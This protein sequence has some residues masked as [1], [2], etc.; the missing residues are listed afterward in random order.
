MPGTLN[1]QQRRHGAH[2]GN[3]SR[4][5]RSLGRIEV[6]ASEDQP[7]QFA[8]I[9]VRYGVEDDYGTLFRPG[10]FT[11]RLG[12]KLPKVCA[13][14]DWANVLGRVTSFK[15]SPADLRF[16]CQLSGWDPQRQEW[17]IPESERAYLQLLDGTIDEFSIGFERYSDSTEEGVGVWI[18]KAGIYEVSLV[19]AG[20]V[21]GTKLLAVRSKP[22]GGSPILHLDERARQTVPVD[23]VANVLT[24]LSLGELDLH[25]ALGELKEHATDEDEGAGN[26]PD[27]SA[28]EGLSDDDLAKVRELAE[29][30]LTPEEVAALVGDDDGTDD[31]DPDDEGGDEGQDEGQDDDPD[32]AA[33]L[34]AA[35]DAEADEALALVDQLT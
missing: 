22:G 15:D 10:C 3:P 25:E 35:L 29:A 12:E 5:F 30:N 21:P 26:D 1:R 16:V 14:H 32:E 7:G 24:R 9:A 13:S 11:E 31:G 27:L 4:E 33:A 18:E 2:G 6:R 28:L 8:I 20:A 17:R 23:E 19:L 34:M